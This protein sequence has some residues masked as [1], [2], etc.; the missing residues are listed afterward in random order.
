MHK[1][2]T[3]LAGADS[4]SAPKGIRGPSV[5]TLHRTASRLARIHAGVPGESIPSEVME[6]YKAVKRGD[7]SRS[8]MAKE[9]VLGIKDDTGLGIEDR[10]VLAA[11]HNKRMAKLADARPKHLLKAWFEARPTLHRFISDQA[12]TELEKWRMAYVNEAMEI[13][14]GTFEY[15][16]SLTAYGWKR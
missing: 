9:A 6:F 3:S 12:G 4:S 8:A 11:R 10:T 15:I 7:P 2:P 16:E 1:F 5:H 14:D 13:F